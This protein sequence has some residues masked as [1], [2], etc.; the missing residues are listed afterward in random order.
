MEEN[1]NISVEK[2]CPAC[3]INCRNFEIDSTSYYGES[4]RGGKVVYRKYFCQNANHCKNLWSYL[5]KYKNDLEG[6]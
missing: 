2:A 1:F 4:F 3:S 5:M 6:H